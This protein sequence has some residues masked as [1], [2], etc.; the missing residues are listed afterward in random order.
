[1]KTFMSLM[2]VYTSLIF[3]GTAQNVGIGT[4]NPEYKLEVV[5]TVHGTSNAYFDGAVGIGTNFPQNKLQINNGGISL[6]NTTDSKNWLLNYSRT[7]NYLSLSENG[8]TRM[9]I[10]NGGNVGIGTTAPTEKLH[11]TGTGRFTDDLI[12]DDFVI[13]DN[14]VTVDGGKG[15]IRNSGP[16]QL[17][18]Y[19]RQ[20]AFTINL[21]AHS[22]STS[23]IKIGFSGF[24]A[25]PVAFVGN[26]VSTGGPVGGGELYRCILQLYNVTAE[27]CDAKIIN[28]DS[29][30]IS[31]D[32]TWNIICIGI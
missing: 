29:Q 30:P 8:T 3:T 7:S 19:T 31:Q 6:F 32:I 13:V 20:A 21:A 24:T 26:I 4:S 15:I 22:A 16:G 1:M 23:V 28:T 17:K 2:I 25:P 11:V 18:Y 14:H 27:G 10:E 5:G 12:V 9:V